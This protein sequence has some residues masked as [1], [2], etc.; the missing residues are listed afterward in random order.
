MVAGTIL[1]HAVDHLY[2]HGSRKSRLYLALASGA[3]ACI[4]ACRIDAPVKARSAFHCSMNYRS[5]VVFGCGQVVDGPDKPGLL[6]RFTERLIPGSADD[7]RPFLAKETKATEL[8]RFTLD[9]ASVKLRTGDPIDDA[10]DIELPHWAG[11]LPIE[12]TYGR[13]IPSADLPDGIDVP[14]GLLRGVRP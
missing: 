13:P 1:P 4:S 7:F 12:S 8:I 6:D 2:L 3:R 14:A 11:I 10:E 9:E 5:A